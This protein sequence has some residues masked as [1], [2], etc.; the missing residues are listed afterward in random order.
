MGVSFGVMVIIVHMRRHQGKRVD[1]D[2]DGAEAVAAEGRR[3][4]MDAMFMPA[5]SRRGRIVLG[6]FAVLAKTRRLVAIVDYMKYDILV[7]LVKCDGK[8]LLLQ[9]V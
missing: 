5:G 7:A 8:D 2:V 3:R 1:L 4:S 6:S 9:H